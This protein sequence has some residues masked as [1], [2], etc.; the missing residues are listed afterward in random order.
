MPFARPQTFCIWVSAQAA[1]KEFDRDVALSTQ[2]EQVASA[3]TQL[4]QQIEDTILGVRSD[5]YVSA[6]EV[7]GYLKV[8]RE[9]DGLDVHRRELGRFFKKG[10]SDSSQDE[11]IIT[12]IDTITGGLPGPA[13]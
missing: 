8:A 10:S 13:L 5:M 6:L 1:L 9:G 12:D 2:L 4:A 3:V 11:D 7:Y